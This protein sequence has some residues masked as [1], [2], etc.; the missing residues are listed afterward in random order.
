MKAQR[1]I[2]WIATALLCGMMLFAA[3]NYIFQ[4]RAIVDVFVRLGFPI[5]II[6]PLAAAKLLGLIGILQ[7]RSKTLKEW[8]YAGFF[9]NFLLA[10]SAHINAGD[11]I[12]HAVPAA[13]C[14]VLLFVSYFW[15]TNRSAR[16]I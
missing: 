4:H 9:F 11:E 7:K 10:L 14:L 2:Y 1:I 12:L 8:A 13:V 3:S 16:L 6:Y 15:Q 5:Y